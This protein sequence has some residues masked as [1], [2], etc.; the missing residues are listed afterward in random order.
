MD[1]CTRPSATSG[2]AD[3]KGRRAPRPSIPATANGTLSRNPDPQRLRERLERAQL[4]LIFTPELCGERDPLG[5]LAELLE[6]VDLVQVRPKAGPDAPGAP[7]RTQ[8]REAHDWCLRVLELIQARPELEVE[9]LV[10]DRV[11]VCAALWEQGLAGVHLGQQDMPCEQARELL[12]P[13][14]LIGC[15][16]HDAA[17][18]VLT[19]EMDVDYLGFGPVHATDTKG[20]ARGL[21]S[22][23]AW[24]AHTA[25]TLPLFAIGGIDHSNV[26]ELQGVERIAVASALLCAADPARAARELRELLNSRSD[27]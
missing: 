24:V 20:Y 2:L 23:A 9:V 3:F 13:H 8:A 17:Q 22:E 12:G 15:S 11:D 4:M 6:F 10:N 27:G 26:A 18:V 25:S 7:A 14:P 1:A 21:G 5:V 19:C 16:T